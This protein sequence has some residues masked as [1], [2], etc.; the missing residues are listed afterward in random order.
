MRKGVTSNFLKFVQDGWDRWMKML[1]NIPFWLFHMHLSWLL[2]NTIQ[3]KW[4]PLILL[5]HQWEQKKPLCFNAIGS[6]CLHAMFMA[7]THL[8]STSLHYQLSLKQW[9]MTQ[10]HLTNIKYIFINHFQEIVCLS[11]LRLH[12]LS[13]SEF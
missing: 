13:Q 2:G 1:K 9:Q 6:Q 12:I 7:F 5:W 10:S 11:M 4:M 3:H 8:I